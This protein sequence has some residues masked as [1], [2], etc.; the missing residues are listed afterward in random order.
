[1]SIDNQDFAAKVRRCRDCGK[2]WER[3]TH[4]NCSQCQ[5]KKQL[6]RR[7]QKRKCAHCLKDFMGTNSLLNRWCSR[8]CYF[9]WKINRR[10]SFCPICNTKIIGRRTYRQIGCSVKCGVKLRDIK[11]PLITER[12][13]KYKEGGSWRALSREIRERDESKCVVCQISCRTHTDHFF[14]FRLVR[15]WKLDPND[16]RNL[17]S[18]CIPHHAEKTHLEAKLFTGDWL[19]FFRGVAAMGFPQ[20]R[21]EIICNLYNVLGSSGKPTYRMVEQGEA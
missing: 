10:V 8:T 21:V 9:A 12:R 20:E 6:A 17:N 7:T 19:G 14:P 5:Y 13:Y 18:L 3:K 11:H 1:V 16:K 4:R 2:P 15:S